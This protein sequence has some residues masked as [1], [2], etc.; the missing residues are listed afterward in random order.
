MKRTTALLLA[1]M[2]VLSPVTVF[3]ADPTPSDIPDLPDVKAPDMPADMETT[4][5]SADS[6]PAAKPPQN[7]EASSAPTSP[8]VQPPTLPTP[9]MGGNIGGSKSMVSTPDGGIIVMSGN[10]I[11][12]FDKDLN[13][14]K[15]IEL[16][17]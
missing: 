16:S 12:K 4:V 14:T 9:S 10:K 2:F 3:A 7:I 15:T 8:S 5:P 11:S 6:T 1:A 17:E 13:V